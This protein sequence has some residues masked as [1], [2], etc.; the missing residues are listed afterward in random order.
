MAYF[1]QYGIERDEVDYVMETFPIVRRKDEHKYGDYRTKRVILE[2]YNEMWRAMEP[3]ELYKTR[4]EPPPADP[5]MMHEPQRKS[6]E[7]F[8]YAGQ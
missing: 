2:S 3:G 4:L 7:M 1:H 5:A 6:R 8:M